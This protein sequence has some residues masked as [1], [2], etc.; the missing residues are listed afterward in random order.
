MLEKRDNR[1]TPPG[2]LRQAPPRTDEK[3]GAIASKMFIADGKNPYYRENMAIHNLE[4]LHQ[5]MSYIEHHEAPW[6][7]DWLE[8]LGDA[9]VARKIRD[10]PSHFKNIVQERWAE[11]KRQYH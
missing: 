4:E 2:V 8:Y 6:V 9:E 10:A 5:N 1:R 11:L 7:A 3:L